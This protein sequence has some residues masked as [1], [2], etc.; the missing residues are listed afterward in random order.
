[1]TTKLF[2]IKGTPVS[3]DTKKKTTRSQYKEQAEVKTDVSM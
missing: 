2:N 3:S 1:M